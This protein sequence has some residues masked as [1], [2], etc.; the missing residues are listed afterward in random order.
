MKRLDEAEKA[1]EKAIEQ[2]K[3]EAKQVTEGKRVSTPQ[4]LIEQLHAQADAEVERNQSARRSA[5]SASC[6]P[7][8]FA[9]C[10]RTSVPNLSAAR[11]ILVSETRL[12][13]RF[14]VR[15]RRSVHRRPRCD[16]AVR[17]GD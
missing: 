13:S 14:A 2:A 9:S 17:S 16:G 12:G 5:G 10:V 6:A 11:A 4:R 7:S 1:H 15:H 3:A 8:W